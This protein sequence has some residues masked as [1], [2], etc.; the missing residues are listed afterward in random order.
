MSVMPRKFED[1]AQVALVVLARPHRSD[2]VDAAARQDQDRAP[3]AEQAL[4]AVLGVAEGAAGADDVVD[5][6]L[7]RRGDAEID[8]GGGDDDRVGGE[9]LVD[10][11][12]GLLYQ[13]VLTP[14]A[15]A[16]DGARGGDE[17]V[18]DVRQWIA[19][20]IADGDAR[21]RDVQCEAP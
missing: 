15:G 9:E 13:G 17:I 19:G 4:G 5:P 10:E 11:D 20:K 21:S 8:H 2:R 12:V 16:G 7:E 14:R 6:R 18:V 1:G 3:P